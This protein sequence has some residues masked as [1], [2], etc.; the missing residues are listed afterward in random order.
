MKRRRSDG[1]WEKGEEDG[2]GGDGMRGEDGLM[3]REEVYGARMGRAE[4]TSN[5]P[6]TIYQVSILDLDPH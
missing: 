6:V 1:G 3:R 5:T 4:P 2:K